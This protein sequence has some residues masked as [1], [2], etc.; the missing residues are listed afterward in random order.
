MDKEKLMGLISSYSSRALEQRKNWYSPAAEAYNQARPSY[1]QAVT[2]QVIE[3]TQLSSESKLLE[4]GCGPGTA[5]LSFAAL[6]CPM[7]CLEPNPD[8]YRLAVNNCQNYPQIELQNTSFEEW[9]LQAEQFDAVLAASSFH[10]IPAEVGYQKA[11]QALKPGGSL[12]LLWNKELQPSQAVHQD[13]SR[14]YAAHAPELDRYED[15]PTQLK[16]LDNLGQIAL[17]SGHFDKISPGY[18]EVAAVHTADQYLT[19]LQT[20]SPYLKLEP[21]RRDALFQELRGYIEEHLDGR[22]PLSHLSAFHVAQKR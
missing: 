1:P 19:L 18:V 4:V 5:T 2:E 9:D 8:F 22:L 11:A 7:L 14:I 16:I 21:Q 12:I 13:L 6:K 17:D 15:K 10:W 3:M 20:Y